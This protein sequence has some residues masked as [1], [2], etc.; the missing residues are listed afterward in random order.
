MPPGAFQIEAG[1]LYERSS[2]GGSPA[3]RRLA[4]EAG[5]RV[6]VTDRLEVR[7]E[8]EPFVRLRGAEEDTG[9]GDLRLGLKYRFLDARAGAWWPSLGVQPFVKLPI[10]SEPIGTERPDLGALALASFDLPGDLGLDLNAGPVLVGQSRPSG[11][12]IQ[13]L[14]S[15][16]LSR[17]LTEKLS[18]FVEIFFASREERQGRDAVGLDAG[19]LYALTPT[20]ALDAAVQTSLAGPGPD[21]A[22][23]AGLSVRFGR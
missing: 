18:S 23:R 6:G 5:L 3:E 21:W 11:H 15:A 17:E 10:A 22:L 20:L 7:L 12:L 14:T 19:L 1:V 9:Y 13:A 4:I 16:S 2:V 8:G